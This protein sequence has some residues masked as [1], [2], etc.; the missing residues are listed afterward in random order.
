MEYAVYPLVAQSEV[1]P[2]IVGTVR[3]LTVTAKV[4]VG[5]VAQLFVPVTVIFPD[6]AVGVKL[7]VIVFVPAPEMMVAPA[8]TVQL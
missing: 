7:T 5:P 2:V 1:K 6:T 4:P 3:G 8:G